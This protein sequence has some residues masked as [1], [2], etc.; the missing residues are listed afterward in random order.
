MIDGQAKH[1]QPGFCTTQ[2]TQVLTARSGD[3]S[4]SFRA[5]EQ[6]C[7]AYWYPLYSFIRR[8]G[9]SPE[10][11]QDLVQDFFAAFLKNNFLQSVERDKGKFRTFLLASTTH[12]LANAWDKR[13]RLKRGG[14][15][16]VISI[17]A[18]QAENRFA[19]EPRDFQTPDRAFERAWAETVVEF[20]LK[21][22][23]QEYARAGEQE[24]FAALKLSLMG[25][26]ELQYKELGEQLGLSEGGIKTAVRRMRVRFGAV[27]REELAQTL[28]ENVDVDEELRHLLQ[29]LTTER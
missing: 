15:C 28:A 10:D 29:A 6:L 23:E 7:Q 22:L 14:G 26:G 25:D 11:A 27:L 24:R 3:S 9:H 5:L 12:F 1:G 4:R 19:S 17:D 18:E 20:A 16:T 21:K 8:K 2:W 13:N